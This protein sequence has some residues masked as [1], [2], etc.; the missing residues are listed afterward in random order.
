MSDGRLPTEVE[1]VFEVMPCNAMR[2]SQEPLGP[3]HPCTYFRQWGT[4]HSYDYDAAG[5]PPQR[6]IVQPS[7][8]LGR[9]NLLPELLSGCR[10][11]PIMAVGINPNL[12]GWWSF[13]RGS[14][15]PDFD[16]FQQ[17]AHYFR[18]RSTAK[19]RL[20]A[21]D[22]ATYRGGTEDSPFSDFVLNVPEDAEGNRAISVELQQQTMYLAYQDLLD[23]L[24]ATMGWAEHALVVGEDL[25]YGNMVACPSAKWTTTP[26]PTDPTL[27]PMTEDQKVGVVTEC[28]HTRRYFLRQLFQSLPAVILVFSQNTANAF[29]GEL[30]S[31]FVMGHPEPGESLE[32]LM[33]REIRLHYGDLPDGTSL[34]ARVIFAP[35][36]T[37]SPA[38]YAPARARVIA[39]LAEEA[40]AGNLR[41]NPDTGHLA[42]PQGACAFC[43]MLE[44]GPC[45]YVAELRPLTEAPQLTADSPASLLREEKV[46]QAR[47]MAGV[48]AA[49]ER[50]ARERVAQV[51]AETDDLPGLPPGEAV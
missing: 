35:H 51:W 14:L 30:Q 27:P 25:A 28:F 38:E 47:L 48:A 12:P 10:K 13:S 49:T 21:A 7:R 46:V 19:L 1:L 6:G 4:Y 40:T 15:N 34:D 23:S 9:A 22:Y 24:A 18:Y 43:P 36:V 17:Y 31:R 37:G 3:P 5:P 33:A 29:V 42:R 11:A 20:P 44:I 2:T 39:Q 45:D 26:D 16:D 8:Y 41:L 32:A 50:D